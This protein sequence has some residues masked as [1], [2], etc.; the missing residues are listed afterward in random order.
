MRILHI[1]TSLNI[2]GAEKLMVDLLPRLKQRG[3]ETEL[4]LFV[5]IRTMFYEQ[6]ESSGVKIHFLSQGGSVYNPQ[7]IFHLYRFLRINKY[8]IIHTHNTAPQLFSALVSVFRKLKLVTTEHSTDNRRRNMLWYKPIDV[9]MYSRYSRVIS[10]SDAAE[11]NIKEYLH[12]TGNSEKFKTVYNGVDINRFENALPTVELPNSKKIITMIAGFRYQKDQDTLIKA[13]SLLPQ[14]KFE[15]WL[16]GDGERRRELESLVVSEGICDGV[17]F[18]G[19]RHD[20]PSILKSSDIIV[21][22]SHFEGLSLSN[23]EGMS[24]GKP[25]IASDV[26]GLHEMTEGAG[27]LFKHGDYRELADIIIK[28]TKDSKLYNEVAEKC[29]NKARQY[30]ISRMVEG[31]IKV[32]QGLDEKK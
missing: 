2:G 8:D 27:L 15:L 13:F 7:K 28:L 16:V 1:I 24:V 30:D 19:V 6:L 31:Y 3:V 29:M 5:G 10:I 26:D 12:I 21:M 32:Y 4:L 22:S 20:V 14:D 17:K 25:F 11:S 18:W 23:I 9:W